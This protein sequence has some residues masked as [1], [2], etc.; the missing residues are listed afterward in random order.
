MAVTLKEF[1]WGRTK[2]LEAANVQ[3]A[4]RVAQQLKAEGS[5]DWFRGQVCDWPPY[6]TFFRMGVERQEE[7]I[8]K[9]KRRMQMFV[10]WAQRTPELKYLTRAGAEHDFFAI[11][12]HY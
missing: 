8:L 1:L 2:V 7:A 4:V 5:Y 3:E 10:Q 9:T 11:L 12:Q 6:A